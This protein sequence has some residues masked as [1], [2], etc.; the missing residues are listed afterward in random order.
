MD[1]DHEVTMGE[2]EENQLA[3]VQLMEMRLAAYYFAIRGIN[4]YDFDD[5]A[6]K[7]AHRILTGQLYE[8]LGNAHRR[9]FMTAVISIDPEFKDKVKKKAFQA[10][11]GEGKEIMHL[12]D[13]EGKSPSRYFSD[14]E[15]KFRAMLARMI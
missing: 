11:L 2:L 13:V 10:Y 8:A 5:S 6:V 1:R 3:A 9:L 4:Q 7:N 12:L 14:V 15:K